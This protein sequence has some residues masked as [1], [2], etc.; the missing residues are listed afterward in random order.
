MKIFSFARAWSLM[1]K[2][3]VDVRS[4]ATGLIVPVDSLKVLTLGCLPIFKNIFDRNGDEPY[5]SMQPKELKSK[6]SEDLAQK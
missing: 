3:S 4:D 1:T 5:E 2:F 6:I